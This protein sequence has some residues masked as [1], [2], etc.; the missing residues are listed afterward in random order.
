ML[1]IGITVWNQHLLDNF[2]SEL[3]AHPQAFE[4]VALISPFIN[5]D[6][7]SLIAKRLRFLVYGLLRRN[8]QVE[9]ASDLTP[10]RVSSFARFLNSHPRFPGFAGLYPRLHTKCGYAVSKTGA[11]IAFV[12]SANLTCAALSRNQEMV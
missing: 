3:E 7:T 8:V 1:N 9:I 2:L 6:S 11:H 12:G 10:A 4:R 5:L